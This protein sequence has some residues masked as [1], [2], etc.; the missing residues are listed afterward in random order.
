MKQH[1]FP[2]ILLAAATLLAPGVKADFSDLLVN[3]DNVATNHE[4]PRLAVAP[5]GSFVVTWADQRNGQSD[6]YLQRVSAAG[7]RISSN[8]LLNFDTLGAWQAYPAIGVAASGQYSTVW[9]DFRNSSYPYDPDVFLQKHDTALFPVGENNSI[10]V[11]LP[12]SLKEA[13]D[14]AIAS[15]GTGMV[16]WADYRN[17][18]WD[19]Y[20]QM[21]AADGS[22]VGSNF[23]VNDE[24]NSSQQHG[25]RVA[26]APDGWY[27]VTWYDSRQGT[28]DIFVQVYSASGVKKGS[29]LKANSD[30]TQTRQAFP[31]IAADGRGR[32]H[33]TWVDWRN[34]TYPNNPDVYYR[35]FDT[36]GAAQTIDTRVNTDGSTRPQRDPAIAADRM[37]NVAMVWAD[38]TASSWDIMGQLLDANGTVQVAGFRAHLPSDSAQLQPDIVLDGRYR[39]VTWSDKRN[40]RFD[41]YTSMVKYNDPHL[42]A[43]PSSVSFTMNPGGPLPAAQ[44]FVV[45][46]AG[47]NSLHY[48]AISS[49]SWL[50]VTPATGQTTDTLALTVTSLLAEGVH[51]AQVRVIDT[52]NA[53]S[54]LIVTVTASSTMDVS[55][56]SVICGAV[57]CLPLDS[58]DL[59]ISVYLE[60]A[61]H[62]MVLPL[63]WDSAYFDMGTVTLGPTLAGRASAQTIS[64]V[65]GE[66]VII[67]TANPSDSLPAGTYKAMD[68]RILTTASEGFSLLDSITIDSF[69]L[70]LEST[71]GSWSRP[72]FVAGEVTVSSTTDVGDPE[73]PRTLPQ[74]G[75]DQNYP[76]PFNL[77]TVIRFT[78]P[79]RADVRLEIFNVL[80]QSVRVLMASPLSAGEQTIVWNGK[81]DDGREAPSGI[82]FY[83]L[84]AGE[85]SL[86]RKMIL[87]K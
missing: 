16:V 20:G 32:F 72:A 50:Q 65:A 78:L 70:H 54:S 80:G 15:N 63:G 18:N 28:D 7:T 62:E 74:F 69:T 44:S 66:A 1:L 45:E 53:D 59:P 22:R 11:E 57:S 82:F 36:T 85:T 29:N 41:I 46:H 55:N 27:V 43:T 77:S 10:T 81:T 47:L 39:Y 3:D 25:A 30:V 84:Q 37:G 34:G 79:E 13:P 67:V 40:G 52:D 58:T 73:P 75:L 61:V 6:I 14:L 86:V 71:Q 23:K 5:S 42:S 17:R 56:D 26:V 64:T 9:Q 60:N 8:Q 83:R 4:R 33:V 21:L 38:S 35:R 68:L 31:D 49:Q 19:I 2:R 24:I 12:D 87:L 48:Q 51:S 76:N